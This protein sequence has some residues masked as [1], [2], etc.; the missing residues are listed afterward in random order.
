VLRQANNWQT[1]RASYLAA[2]SAAVRLL[3]DVSV[4]RKKR[5]PNPAINAAVL[6]GATREYSSRNTPSSAPVG[7]RRGDAKAKL[8]TFPPRRDMI[9]SPNS[10][11]PRDRRQARQHTRRRSGVSGLCP[12]IEFNHRRGRKRVS[13]AALRFD[14]AAARNGCHDNARDAMR[15]CTYDKVGRWRSGLSNGTAAARCG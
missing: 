1:G 9:A 6:I 4:S 3:P 8:D 2:A 12:Q 13:S 5:S 11:N 10:T 14:I 7:E 15:P